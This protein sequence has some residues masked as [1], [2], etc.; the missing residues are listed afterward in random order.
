MKKVAIVTW[1]GNGN[2]GTCLQAFALHYKVKNMGYETYFLPWLSDYGKK[3]Y[4]IK[5]YVKFL[6]KSLGISFWVKK[7]KS[8]YIPLNIIKLKKFQYKNINVVEINTSGEK[9]K[10]L[11]K[12][13]VFIA[14]SDQ[15]W[16]TYYCF[17]S[18]FFLGLRKR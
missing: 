7:I 14:G 13:D 6:F 18:F 9:D 2:Y 1:I 11:S 8:L 10:F 12:I 15:I 17:N 5:G 16:N 4:I 3:K